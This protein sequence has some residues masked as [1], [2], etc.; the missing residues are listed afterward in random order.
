[1][2]TSLT[3]LLT[4][5]LL[6]PACASTP[7]PETAP[8]ILLETAFGEATNTH[9]FGTILT[10]GQ[11]S[12]TDL[13][14]ARGQQVKTIVTLRTE[15]EL[16]WNERD[17]VDSLGMTFVEIPFRA[18]DT[19]TDDIFERGRLV[20]ENAQQPLILHCGSANRVG[21]LWLP[22]RVLDGGLSVEEALAEAKTVGLKTPEY[23][24]RA[25]DYISRMQE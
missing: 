7:K 17:V 1:M 11:L 19:L 22:W 25:L 5:A 16:E 20:L 18:P 23:E 13:E 3:L 14:F 21:A 15:G 8:P 9:S 10:A 6:F 24:T 12:R 4:A 2:R